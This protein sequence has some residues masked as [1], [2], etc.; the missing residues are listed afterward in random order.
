MI[1]TDDLY[2][3]TLQ[4][5][6]TDASAQYGITLVR[7]EVRQVV[8]VRNPQLAASGPPKPPS[9]LITCTQRVVVPNQNQ[10]AMAVPGGAPP[11][12][13]KWTT[14]YGNYPVLLANS[15]RIAPTDG[16]QAVFNPRLVKYSPRTLNASVGRS[17]SQGAST[18]G[19][20]TREHTSGSSYSETNGYSVSASLGFFGADP[21]GSV[22]GSYDHS[23]TDT[24]STSDSAG[25][26]AGSAHD[27]TIG[28]SMSIKDW[29][30][31][32][33]LAALDD[34]LL[35]PN[36]PTWLWGQEY[37]WDAMQ[38]R[39]VAQSGVNDAL[40]VQLP[41]SMQARLFEDPK[42]GN[43]PTVYPP[44]QLSLFG[45]DFTMKATWLVDLPA[46]LTKQS[47]TFEHAV[48]L[49][50]GS[51]GL[52]ENQAE[53]ITQQPITLALSDPQPA[54][55]S[56]LDLTLLGLDPIPDGSASNGAVLGFLAPDKFIVPPSS[57]A[58]EFKILSDAN[59]LQAS[60]S[61]FEQAMQSSFSQGKASLDLDFKIVDTD[62]QYALFLKHWNTSDTVGCTL[63][64]TINGV[65]V[66]TR[67]VDA[68]EGE[69]GD[70]NMTVI[71]LRNLSYASIN[72][73]DYLQ[74]GHNNIHID[75]K[76]DGT[77]AGY[78]LRAV[79]IGQ[80]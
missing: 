20:T 8:D 42:A 48:E 37:P 64:I 66:L 44:S 36:I 18:S 45:I 34:T 9:Y 69:G 46:D 76:P 52:D 72:Y 61:G 49:G 27:V 77:G 62:V 29:S 43:Q 25:S 26:S 21:T 47:L 30:S 73:H 23:T 71:S 3:A 33:Q 75:I 15:M 58:G 70:D 80:E 57:S 41:A 50:L 22:S 67:H 63:N 28:D 35:I 24:H 74:L 6:L 1:V 38:F 14:G 12:Q 11:S 78:V 5:L 13:P 39:P 51:H 2:V 17:I 53:A 31:C 59:T 19:A 65:S 55:G 32:V 4:A 60:G 10:F 54:A 56:S 79:A 68:M 7:Y 16:Q 40:A